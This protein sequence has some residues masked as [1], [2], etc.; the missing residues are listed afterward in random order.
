M[1]VG[2]EVYLDGAE[3]PYGFE[4]LL[5]SWRSAWE[6]FFPEQPAIVFRSPI[7]LK[8]SR[9]LPEDLRAI[10]E[11]RNPDI[12]FRL[13][14][15]QLLGGV[16][17]TAHSPDGSNIEKR[18]P[19]LWASR[20][21][22]VPGFVATPYQKW[23]PGGAVNRLPRRH[24]ERNLRHLEQW[25]ANDPTKAPIQLLAI[26]E[27]H[28]LESEYIDESVADL[29]PC[30]A[31]LGQF[32]AARTAQLT[33][34]GSRAVA[35]NVLVGLRERWMTFSSAG[36]A[37]TTYTEAST[38]LRLPGRWVQIYNARPDTGHWERG[39]GQFDS[40]D[41]RL[42]FT[43]ESIEFTEAA[44]RPATLEFWLPQMVSTHPWI[45]EQISRGYGS[46]RLR[47]VLQVLP[48][49]ARSATYS[50]KFADQ[51]TDAD[52]GLLRQNRRLCLE[53]L[54]ASPA[55]LRISDVVAGQDLDRLCRNGLRRTTAELAVQGLARL[56]R[57]YLSTH[58][59]YV[60]DWANSLELELNALPPGEIA[61]LPRIP[62]RLSEGLQVKAG[63]RLLPAEDT[64]KA[65]LLALRQMHRAGLLR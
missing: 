5:E 62:R 16:E 1:V 42:M 10:A 46:K 65:E 4:A 43:L 44:D 55:L 59:A 40:I 45:V 3:A 50:V 38:L 49:R 17:V 30:W 24:M 48:M 58:R 37:N 35:D 36:I 13:E 60:P 53:R 28:G 14:D 57:A 25:D 6:H 22:G 26:R 29:M 21:A 2:V 18:Y 20:E 51:L 23:R 7:D 9:E 11:V 27:L 61:Y 64:T 47:N 56:M 41:G 34:L 19:Y 33:G 63:V 31:D 52:W 32:F 8:T 54:D 39:E 12:F 15:G